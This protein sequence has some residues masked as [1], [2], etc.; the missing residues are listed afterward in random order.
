MDG[1]TDNLLFCVPALAWSGIWPGVILLWILDEAL[2]GSGPSAG[3]A[4]WTAWP[5]WA[6][7]GDSLPNS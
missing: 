1:W 6:V 7:M 4:L 3:L 2:A 5:G